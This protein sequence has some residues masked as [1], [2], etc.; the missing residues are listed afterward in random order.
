[1]ENNPKTFYEA[2]SSRDVAFWKEATND[3]NDRK[4][5]VFQAFCLLDSILS[6][7][8]WI[9]VDL[10]PGSNPIGYK[11]VFRRKYNIDGFI[12]TFKARSIAKDFAQ[13]ENDYYFNTY[14][15]MAR[16]TSI[17]DLFALPSIYKL[18]VHKMDVKTTFLN[19]DLKEEAYIE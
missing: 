1:M 2:M 3:E 6:K 12:Q 9:L 16:I 11:W 18:Y 15:L 13:K 7:Y 14:S 4:E 8:T 10:P 5:N 19:W 17:R